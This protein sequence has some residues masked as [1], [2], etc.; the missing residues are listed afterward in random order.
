MRR[1]DRLRAW[2]RPIDRDDPAAVDP[3]LVE[4]LAAPVRR[5]GELYH[6]L[7][8]DGLEHLPEGRALV[9]G[10]HDSGTVFV[11]A[12]CA[13]ARVVQEGHE[14]TGLAHDMVID[15]PVLGRLLARIGAVRAGHDSAARAFAAGRK[16]VVFP[17]GNLEAFRSWRD[18]NRVV[19]GGRTGF[20]RLALRHG[21]DIVPWVF[22]GG[23][24]SF[25][26]LSDGRRVARTLGADRW[27]RSDTWPLML[28]L[29]W[30]VAFGP[31]PHLPLPVKVRCRFLPPVSVAS[32]GPEAA[33]DGSVVQALYDEVTARMQQGLDDLVAERRRNGSTLWRRGR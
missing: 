9:V 17:G 14:L 15:A 33:D 18:R 21:V 7:E 11:E 10:N 13:G 27:L 28:G 22:H 12:L 3:H 23:S 20:V 8:V 5:W 29:P 24:R 32:Y 2:L 6:R 4:R 1:R 25:V 30:G 26:I 16:V 31:W 19:F